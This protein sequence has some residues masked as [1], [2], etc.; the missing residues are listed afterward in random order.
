MCVCNSYIYV[1][2]V[3]DENLWNTFSEC[4]RIEAVRAVKDHSTGIGKGFGYVLFS[5]SYLV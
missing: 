4:G 3:E 1:L 5:V 2:D